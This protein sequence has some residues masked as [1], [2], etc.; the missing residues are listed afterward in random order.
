MN[1]TPWFPIQTPPV[2]EGEYEVKMPGAKRW[3]RVE[4]RGKWDMSHLPTFFLLDVFLREF[5]WR[6]LRSAAHFEKEKR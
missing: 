4:W 6:G 2:R 3:V 1:K 5:R